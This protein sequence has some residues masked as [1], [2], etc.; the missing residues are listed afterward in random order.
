MGLKVLD[1]TK[2]FINRNSIVEALS[3]GTAGLLAFMVWKPS[4]TMFLVIADLVLSIVIFAYYKSENAEFLRKVLLYNSIL[5]LAYIGGRILS[6][7]ISSYDIA[8]RP[9]ITY[10]SLGI[11]GAINGLLVIGS[12][13]FTKILENKQKKTKLVSDF[14]NSEIKISDGFFKRRE[15]DLERLEDYITKSNTVGINGD[16]GTG[17]TKLTKEFKN[18]HEKNIYSLVV[19]VLTCNENELELFLISELEKLLSEH[20]IYSK[21]A[22]IL[23]DIMSRQSILKEVRQFIWDDDDLKAKIIDRYKKDIQKL[24]RPVIVSIED[25]DRLHNE[26]MIKK[27]LDFTNRMVC[28]EIRIIYEYDSVRLKKC[29]VDR[30][31]IEKYIPYVVNLSPIPF[32]EVV[33]C[34]EKELGIDPKEYDFLTAA[35]H[36]EKY[37][38]EKLGMEV[39]LRMEYYNPSLRKVKTFLEE[40]LLYKNNENTNYNYEKNKNTIITFLFMRHFLPD[41]YDELEF[42]RDCPEEMKLVSPDTGK[43]YSILELLYNLNNNEESDGTGNVLTPEEIQRLFR[44]EADNDKAL[45]QQKN[46]TK[47]VILDR[48]GYVFRYMYERQ[49]RE[50]EI[51]NEQNI[52]FSKSKR[53]EEIY[54][55]PSLR[56]QFEFKNDKISRL[57]KNLHSNGLSE[58]T[59]DE[60]NAKLFIKGVLNA[61]NRK[62]AWENYYSKTYYGRYERDNSTIF[63]TGVSNDLELAKALSIYLDNTDELSDDEKA[64]IWIKLIEFRSSAE[65]TFVIDNHSITTEYISFCNYI[66]TKSRKVFV[67][68]IRFFNQMQV[69]GNLKIEKS[70]RAFLSKY[71]RGIRWHGYMES[72][73]V[74]RIEFEDGYEEPIS[75]ILTYLKKLPEEIEE[76]MKSEILGKTAIEE[77]AELKK[78]AEKNVE[79]LEYE[80]TAK[81]PDISFQTQFRSETHFKD[82]D[83]YEQMELLAKTDVSKEQFVEELNRNYEKERLSILEIEKLEKFYSVQ[84][85]KE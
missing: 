65:K 21:N 25:L 36:P 29:G 77:L 85:E 15:Y 12:I 13:V 39:E 64:D 42:N 23:K 78:F 54:N 70:Y 3:V 31:Y 63:K 24:D 43:G 84:R 58:N 28:P 33:K 79:I 57:V 18:R 17:K 30:E 2:K 46:R 5:L 7:D 49:L 83:T 53:Y 52:K 27:L 80:I 26:K 55:E 75:N 22:K 38:A 35:I 9:L 14:T 51:N 73:Y 81:R 4:L 71:F 10:I 45:I 66:D 68:E 11:Y 59:N 67:E 50:K 8:G 34:F 76:K 61:D 72:F 48:M 74:N 82:K 69:I 47:Y 40:T 16:W 37:I 19:D 41:I 20:H 1:K 62:E 56:R 60:E 6:G 32:H 44:G